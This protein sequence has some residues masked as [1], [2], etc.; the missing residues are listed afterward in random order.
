MLDDSNV[1][2][3][4]AVPKEENSDDLLTV[5]NYIIE[6]VLE[7]DLFN[8]WVKEGKELQDSLGIE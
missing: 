2:M 8:T 3:A 5:V 6:D 7:Q 4:A 1:G